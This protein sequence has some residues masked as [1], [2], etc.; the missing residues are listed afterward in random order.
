M[1]SVPPLAAIK[2]ASDVGS[3]VGCA[4]KRAGWHPILLEGPSPGVTRRLM[5]FAPAVWEGRAELAGLTGV[6]CETAA[7]ALA[8]RLDPG[9][10]PVLV[11]ERMDPAAHLAPDVVVDA[12][13][14]KRQEP[15]IQI[16]EAPLALGI[17]PGFACG[18][19]VHGVIES[20]WGAQLGRVLW[21]GRSQDYTGKHREIGGF[22]RER[23]LY[24]PDA[25]R[26]R[27]HHDVL[28]PVRHGEIVGWVD[29]AP[30]RAG[31]A[32]ILRGL[33]NDGLRVAAG[34]K[35][36]EID[37]IGD[38]ARCR[39]IGERPAAIAEGVLAALR[40]RGVM[41]TGDPAAPSG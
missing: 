38:P 33:A 11:V 22:G 20:N 5:A 6:R 37:P 14:R 7:Q 29:S 27:T 24:A 16:G 21:S 32:G 31:I 4:L 26:F 41:R 19:H 34:A 9:L 2:S 10:L 23:Y 25:G 3:A 17:G 12:R 8:L 36:V 28:D 40:E 15:P 18:R 39:G 13:M 35:L 1:T 30:L